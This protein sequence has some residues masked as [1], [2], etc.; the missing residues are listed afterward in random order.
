[1]KN[2]S[3]ILI[4]FL[5]ILL[6]ISFTAQPVLAAKPKGKLVIGFFSL[7][8]EGLDAIR[9]S[10]TRDDA[11]LL[12]IGEALVI[13]EWDGPNQ[14]YRPALASSWKISPD[15]KSI[16][17]KLRKDAKFQDGTPV[18][19]EDVMYTWDRVQN[20]PVCIQKAAVRPLKSVEAVGD[21]TVRF[22]IKDPDPFYIMYVGRFAIQPKAYREK[23]GDKGYMKKPIYAGPWK[24]VKQVVGTSCE[25]EAFEGHYRKTP[26]A[27]TLILKVIPESAT[28]LAA[29]KTG[30]VDVLHRMNIGPISEEIRKDPNLRLITGEHVSGLY[31]AYT[32]LTDPKRPKSK[33]DDKRVRWALSHGIDRKLIVDKLFYG[34]GGYGTTCC[35]RRGTPQHDPKA[36]RE[37]DPGKARA[38]LKDA[39]YDNNLEVEMFITTREK[40]VAETISSMWA[41]IGV[42][43]K[44]TMLERQTSA[45]KYLKKTLPDG[46]RISSQWESPVGVGGYF[47][48]NMTWSKIQDDKLDALALKMLTY[49]PGP[50]M[51]KFIRQEMVPYVHDFEPCL[52]IA[53]MDI[54]YGVRKELGTAEWEKHGMRNWNFCPIAE[55]LVPYR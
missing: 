25:M 33:F 45:Q 22:T 6:V 5:L 48:K 31:G 2:K 37:Y 24:F 30:E 23:V 17:F 35:V 42:K 26:Y 7:G 15:L 43:T 40:L 49:P 13:V 54:A 20:D 50:E 16:T 27:K 38:L 46:I 32:F 44:I 51:V 4:A 55:Y 12:T 19:I 28:Q 8:K 14:L 41:K 21:D 52:T 39:G 47:R 36:Y 34:M 53:N 10:G 9:F 11:I 1:M 18:T 29:L 3:P